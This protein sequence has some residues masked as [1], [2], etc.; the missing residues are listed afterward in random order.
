VYESATFQPL[1]NFSPN[2]SLTFGALALLTAVS[3]FAVVAPALQL[4]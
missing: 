4:P 1:T 2:D 3:A